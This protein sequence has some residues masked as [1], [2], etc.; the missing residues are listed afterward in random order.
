MRRPST[1]VAV[2]GYV[3]SSTCIARRANRLPGESELF[4]GNQ[5]VVYDAIL[6]RH[7]RRHVEVTVGVGLDASHI[8]AGMLDQDLVDGCAQPDN[9]FRGNL[10]IGG[11]TLS[12]A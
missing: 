12:T 4:A 6:F 7:V 11:L 3:V 1:W 9:L 8:L 2:Q 10:D 5:Y